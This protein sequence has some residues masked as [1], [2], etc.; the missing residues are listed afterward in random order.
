MVLYGNI[1]TRSERQEEGI[2]KWISSKCR[3]TLQWATGVGK[4]RASI[5]AITKFLGKN[6]GKKVVVIVPSDYLK[7]QWTKILI[8]NGFFMNVDV[9]IINTA[10]K[11]TF[12]AD[13]LIID[14]F[15]RYKIRL[16]A[17]SSLE[18]I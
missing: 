3:G 11:N 2:Q 4:T 6:P 5:L 9:K 14:K 12:D 18:L 13:L 7:E 17:G 10:I 16:I 1:M 15:C 8:E